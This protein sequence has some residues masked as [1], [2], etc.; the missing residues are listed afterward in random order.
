MLGMEP[1]LSASSPVTFMNVLTR[2]V[3][4]PAF[5][6]KLVVFSFSSCDINS[7]FLLPRIV[8]TVIRLKTKTYTCP[9]TRLR[10]ISYHFNDRG[11]FRH[12]FKFVLSFDDLESERFVSHRN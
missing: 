4:T 9:A 2:P 10:S 3:S 6:V 8:F 1:W 7:L 11:N 12:L 5:R